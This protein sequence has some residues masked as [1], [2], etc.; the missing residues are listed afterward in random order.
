MQPAWRVELS[1]VFCLLLLLLLATA[2]DSFAS[3]NLGLEIRESQQS[4][5][6][7]SCISY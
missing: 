1:P 3:A 4:L 2:A 5:S 6:W 7:D